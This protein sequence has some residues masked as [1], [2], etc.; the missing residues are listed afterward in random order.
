M[1]SGF[2]AL[3]SG[4]MTALFLWEDAER[5]WSMYGPVLFVCLIFGFVALTGRVPG[6]RVLRAIPGFQRTEPPHELERV[7][8][9]AQR[10]RR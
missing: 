1:I 2:L 5:S 9:P 7:Q 10:L 4:L 3:L 8:P 6:A